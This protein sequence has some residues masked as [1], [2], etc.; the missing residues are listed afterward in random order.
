MRRRSKNSTPMS[1]FSF[2]D[3]ITAITGILILLALVLALSVIIQGAPAVVEVIKA[4]SSRVAYR[5][6]LM[7][8]VELLQNQSKELQEESS[9]WS[10]ATPTELSN[11]L[12]ATANA[13]DQLSDEIA[14]AKGKKQSVED[15]LVDSKADTEA[16][17][18]LAQIQLLEKQI[19]KSSAELAA[20]MSSNRVVYNFRNTTKTPWLVEISGGKILA[21][22]VGTTGVPRSFDSVTRFNQFANGRPSSEQYFV[23]VVKPSGSEDSNLIRT[24]LSSENMDIGIELIGEDQVAIDP[25]KGA[26]F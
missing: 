9:T 23:L 26:G 17:K 20:L 21:A 22:K 14:K 2:Q 6:S 15:S 10:S 1:L 16:A 19:K 18:K 12:S 5:D 24:Y 13:V 11:K 4:D 7:A 3:I 8:E 25:L